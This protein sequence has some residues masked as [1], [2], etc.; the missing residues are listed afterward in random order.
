M[1][2]FTANDTPTP[3]W[4]CERH[5]SPF[6]NGRRI[7]SV[8]KVGEVGQ[9][10]TRGALIG[11]EDHDFADRFEA[12]ELEEADVRLAVGDVPVYSTCSLR[13]AGLTHNLSAPK[14]VPALTILEG[15]GCGG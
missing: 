5:R 4:G 13:V 2:T 15:L 11:Y 14:R 7:T 3:T 1:P 8:C 9:S 6:R 12:C 10:I